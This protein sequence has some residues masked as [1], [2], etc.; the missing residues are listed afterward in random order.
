[1]LFGQQFFCGLGVELDRGVGAGALQEADALDQMRQGS[2]DEQDKAHGHQQL[3]RP[4]YEAARVGRHLAADER[5]DEHG[6]A[7]PQHQAADRQQEEQHAE[8]LDLDLGAFR[9]LGGQYVDPNV[10]VVEQGI[11]GGQQENGSEQIPLK[12]EPGVRTHVEDLAADG[13]RGTDDH[14]YQNHPGDDL[15]DQAAK[16]VD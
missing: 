10:L 6:Y 5:V 11:A 13:V 9:E 1:D 8:D 2:E 3:H 4:P 7:H 15:A 12:L 16:R 14:H